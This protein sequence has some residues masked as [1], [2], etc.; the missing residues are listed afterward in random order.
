M[1]DSKTTFGPSSRFDALPLPRKIGLSI[2]VVLLGYG[3]AD[4]A[5]MSDSGTHASHK[6][7]EKAALQDFLV[8]LDSQGTSSN[9][10]AKSDL[11]DPQGPIM[12]THEADDVSLSPEEAFVKNVSYPAPVSDSS[13]DT[14]SDTTM[15]SSKPQA[16]DGMLILPRPGRDAK[17]PDSPRIRLTGTIYPNSL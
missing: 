3:L 4:P 13:S 14:A 8:H 9:D 7:D 15:A 2:V 5:F 12:D 1:D 16:D 17:T 6:V 10:V 11:A